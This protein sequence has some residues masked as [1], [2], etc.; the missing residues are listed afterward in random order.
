MSSNKRNTRTKLFPFEVE[1][2]LLKE[3]IDIIYDIIEVSYNPKWPEK[4]R[5]KYIQ[6]VIH[7]NCLPKLADMASSTRQSL[8][9][10]KSEIVR[11]IKEKQGI[12]SVRLKGEK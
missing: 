9:L 2:K 1:L 11:D 8:R 10:I 6:E 3:F 4:F 12:G 7:N 5:E